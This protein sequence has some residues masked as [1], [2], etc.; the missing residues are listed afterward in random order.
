[1][2]LLKYKFEGPNTQQWTRAPLCRTW[3]PHK[4]IGHS[5]KMFANDIIKLRV[6]VRY[7]MTLSFSNHVGHYHLQCFVYLFINY[8]INRSLM[9][10]NDMSTN[11]VKEIKLHAINDKKTKKSSHN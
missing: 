6:M 4:T 3:A 7:Y 5:V 11:A 8:R 9:H 2:Q 10:I 1:M